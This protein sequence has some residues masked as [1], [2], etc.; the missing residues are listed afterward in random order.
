MSSSSY[1]NL[2][3]ELYVTY[4]GRPA[5]AQGLQNFSAALAA[6]SAP[7]DAAGLAAAYASNS[8]VQVLINSFGTSPESVLLYGQVTTSTASATAFV[9]AVF[10]NLLD[11]APAASGLNFWVSS[12]TSG[13][14]SLGDAA[15]AIASGAETNQSAQG[16]IDATTIANKLAVAA[17]FTAS[18]SNS[19]GIADYSGP[20]A[21][22]TARSLLAGATSTTTAQSYQA[23]VAAA[24][25]TLGAQATNNTYTLTTGADNLSGALGSNTFNAVLDNAAG[26]AAGLPAATLNAGDSITPAGSDN[27]LNISDYGLGGTLTI[28]Q[29]T[30]T[31]I[32]TLNL[33]SAES[34]G[35]ADFSAWSGLQTL[36]IGLSHGSDN[37][38][39]A[40]GTNLIVRDTGSTGSV[41]TNGGA[42]VAIYSDVN[43]TVTVNGGSA[44]KTVSVTG[45]SNIIVEDANYGT[46]TSN[47]ITSVAIGNPSGASKIESNALTALTVADD[48][49]Q[50]VTAA[51]SVALTA[52]LALMLDGD[53]SLTVSAP[54]A[55]SL[56][57]SAVNNDSSAITLSA[58]N[59]GAL[60]FGGDADLIVAS[61]TASAAIAVSI[62]TSGELSVNLSEIGS[63]A[64][65]DASKSSGVIDL[66]LGGS[67]SFEGGTGADNI[68]VGALT[69]T[70]AAGSAGNN[71]IDFFNVA[72]T[73]S[74]PITNFSNFQAWEFSGSSS[75][76]LDMKNAGPYNDLIVA[77][78]GGDLNFTDLH[79]DTP[80]SILASDSHTVSLAF[81]SAEASGA[82]QDV[83]LGTASTTGITLNDL[84]LSGYANSGAADVD[85]SSSSTSGQ[86]NTINALVDGKLATFD[87]SGNAALD[88]KAALVDAVSS[89]TINDTVATGA[90]E[91]AGLSDNALSTLT[92]NT[93]AATLGSISTSATSFNL[94]GNG[95]GAISV[96]GITDTLATTATISETSSSTVTTNTIAIGASTLSAL[97]S[98]TLNGYVGISVGGIGY[99]S[100]FTLAGSSD[101][102]AVSFSSSGA[103]NFGT[104]DSI[105]L[106]NG[107]DQV[108]LGQGQIGSNQDVTLGSGIDSVTTSST[109]NV[110]ITFTGDVNTDS[111]TSTGNDATLHV[112]AGGGSDQITATG[113]TD[114]V[115]I[116]V[117]GGADVV[118]LGTDATG[119]VSF[120]THTGTDSLT[121][122]AVG[123]LTN[124]NSIL[125]VSGL[126]NAGTDTITFSDTAGGATGIVQ[127]T[128]ANVTASGGNAT[129]LADWFAAALG[130]DGIV[131]QTAHGLEW[132]QFG[133]NT[134]LVE[135]STSNDNGHFFI[136]DGAVELT[137]TGYTFAHATF[138]GGVLH[139][140][141]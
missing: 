58:P 134:Y 40:S 68:T 7:A 108:A 77:G 96:G 99:T 98:L 71:S 89:L 25:A 29:S 18:V 8:A 51:A 90:F 114:V 136:T 55:L 69:E 63:H 124:Y 66:A 119:S 122:G 27:I 16:L 117:G 127:V 64:N 139:L 75:G 86:V 105:Q 30:I 141:G 47:V 109:G 125:A 74:S 4:F 83:T 15:L 110:N 67:Q 106:G 24:V 48:N 20:A 44:T 34:I 85:L 70:V 118:T 54:A 78:A 115:N 94:V 113:S 36:N 56:N 138:T 130:K 1:Q 128:A 42:S 104:T 28:A 22:L 111:V 87:I 19:S 95:A 31:G 93:Y 41:T 123:G 57:V 107:N 43:H 80:V 11:R 92:L 82:V 23:E 33:Q 6:A 132:F 91:L 131:P 116:T 133:G 60:S 5:D 65:I 13:S 120:G 88:I 49:G 12:I 32:T 102:A 84:T 45:G 37:V 46:S 129:T 76:T 10:E 135:T 100:G 38:T 2:V 53:N 79:P 3:Q 72:F 73:T 52:P 121:I 97:Q 101:N 62:T 126:N 14:L 9:T 140:L 35:T 50:N 39:V 21:A 61:L 59:A 81:A 17:Q 112:T 103:T 26:V 137:G